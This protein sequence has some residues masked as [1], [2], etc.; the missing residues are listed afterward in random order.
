MYSMILTAPMRAPH[1]TSPFGQ[2]TINCV[3]NFHAGID[4]APADG[5]GTVL[6]VARGRV[7][8]DHDNY[9]PAL[10][11]NLQAPDSGGRMVIL[12]HEIDGAVWFT[13]YLHLDS[14]VV[15]LGQ[16]VEAGQPIGTFGNLGYSY[17][18][19]LHF[20]MFNAGWQIIDPT[21]L[22]PQGVWR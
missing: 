18:A 6:A 14:N 8:I 17:G 20:D 2:R 10:R 3:P 11:Y 12:Q 21:P 7:I 9:N 13:R 1:I 19:H 16:I 22:F 15:S 5:D 4:I